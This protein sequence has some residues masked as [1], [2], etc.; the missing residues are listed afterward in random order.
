[1]S[2]FALSRKTDLPSFVLLLRPYAARPFLSVFSGCF[3]MLV[4][5]WWQVAAVGPGRY[6]P[7]TTLGW[8][9]TI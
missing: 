9:D 3:L 7:Q 1:M 4:L 6:A 8:F 5:F 2:F